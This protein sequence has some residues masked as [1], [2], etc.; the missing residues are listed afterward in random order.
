MSIA[1][2]LTFLIAGI[3]IM[4][5]VYFIQ[6]NEKLIRF[7]NQTDKFVSDINSA[8]EELK[9]QCPYEI[10]S[11]IPL[12]KKIS[13]S[14]KINQNIRNIIQTSPDVYKNSDFR[15]IYNLTEKIKMSNKFYHTSNDIYNEICRKFPAVIINKLTGTAK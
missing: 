2:I 10:N 14:E 1:Y 9:L 4:T 8:F 15:K 11:D 13:V 7:K 3:I 5:A 6:I 12:E